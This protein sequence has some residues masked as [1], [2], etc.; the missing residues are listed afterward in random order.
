MEIKRRDFLRL[1]GGVSGALLIDGCGLDEVFDLPANMIEKAKKGA[2]I[3][4]WSSTICSLCPGGCGIQVRMIDGIPVSVKGNRFYPVNLGGMCPLGI[5]ALHE[6]YNPDRAKTPLRRSGDRG[7]G[8]W[9]PVTWDDALK[10]VSEKLATVRKEG[11]SHQVGFL[12]YNERG[13]MREHISRFMRAFGSPNYYQFSLTQNDTVAYQL[14]QG[15]S[16]VPA[17]D[18]LNAKLIMSFGANFLEG[19]YSP[20]YHTKLYSHHQDR[21]TRFVQIES[22]MSL[23]GANADRWVP[24]RP[25]TYGALALGIA[26]VLIREEL[27]DKEFVK[28]RTFG[29][30]D[31]VDRFGGKHTGFK[32][33]VLGNYYPE[34]ASQITGVPSA[35][36]L[37]LARELGN[38][39]PS[40]VLG[41]GGAVANTN[42]TFALMA[43]HSLNALLGNIER[44][45]GVLFIDQPPVQKHA[46]VSE[47]PVAR[48]GNHQTPIAQ[49]DEIAFPMT[50]FS[51]ES[52]AQHVLAERPYPLR[53]LFLYRGNA[54]FQSLNHDD[55]VN[56]LKK[57]DLIVSFDSVINETSEY[58][59]LILPDHTFLEKW[60][61]VSN[62]PSVGFTHVGIQHPVI[63]PLHDTRHTGDVLIELARRVGGTVGAAFPLN[64]YEEEIK[65]RMKGV[66]LSG[67]GAV[68]TQG[69]RQLWLDYLQQRGWQIGR[70]ASFEEF[71]D[72]LL[73]HGG[74]WNPIRKKKSSSEV[75]RT[76]SGKFEFYS[77]TL[78][79]SVD[80][81]VAKAGAP[82]S[83][84]NLDLVLNRLNISARGDSVFLPH[85]EPVSYEEDKPLYLIPFHVLPNPDG[86]AANLPMMQEMFGYTARRFWSSWVE[87]HPETA[88]Q[89]AIAEDSWVWVETSVGRLKVQAKLS[90]A[91]VPNVIAIPFGLGHTSYGRYAKGHGVNPHSIIRNLYDLISGKA[92]FEAT[93]AKITLAS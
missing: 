4:A 9:E 86:Q 24:V 47:D 81:L 80:R 78:K 43:V 62:V 49:P 88:A 85:H 41:D 58:A 90:H 89:Y 2:G 82:R 27:Y 60:D 19:G 74:W 63:Q 10:T 1:F 12:G 64:T 45:G 75:F 17:Y 93:K 26:Y 38:T 25:G 65:F 39:R 53:I 83:F 44:G 57:I 40:V 87:I 54:L 28:N 11:K 8:K 79:A 70:Y 22:R 68:A 21:N 14:L 29:F 76:P 46:M 91:I 32:S 6:L 37:E 23:T 59:D 73:E 35:T 16:Q 3:E 61:E 72:R 42:G 52:F 71:W 5:N 34:R 30:E 13:L 55:L 36:I 31:W 15:Q 69:V 50:D 56:A 48:T 33:D 20:V 77:Q 7:S 92:A 67:E 51:I 18:I 66:Y 84:Q